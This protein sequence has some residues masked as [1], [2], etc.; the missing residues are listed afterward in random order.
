LCVETNCHLEELDMSTA[1]VLQW[2]TEV[3]RLVEF[4]VILDRTPVRRGYYY[5]VTVTKFRAPQNG[6]GISWSVGTHSRKTLH[7]EFV[8]N[9]KI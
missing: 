1:L 4:E 5:L 7:H 9:I 2:V 3:W 6:V 8:T